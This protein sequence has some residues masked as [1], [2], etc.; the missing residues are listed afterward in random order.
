M[1]DGEKNPNTHR[2]MQ[3]L[4]RQLLLLLVVGVTCVLDEGGVVLGGGSWST[5]VAFG[6][7]AALWGSCAD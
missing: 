5:G 3:T 1:V 4:P 7:A 6:Q 2:D